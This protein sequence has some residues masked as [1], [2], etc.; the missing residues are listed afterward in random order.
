M[1]QNPLNVLDKTQDEEIE[2]RLTELIHYVPSSKY[3]ELDLSTVIQK[4]G[5]FELGYLRIVNLK[6]PN[7]IVGNLCQSLKKQQLDPKNNK[8]GISQHFQVSFYSNF[9]ADSSYTNEAKQV[10]LNYHDQVEELLW[11]DFEIAKMYTP[12]NTFEGL[13]RQRMVAIVW[14]LDE[15]TGEYVVIG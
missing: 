13:K 15:L 8:P 10:F 6:L 2:A 7:N 5:I 1:Q 14:Y 3:Q 4:Y 12:I 9:L 11:Q